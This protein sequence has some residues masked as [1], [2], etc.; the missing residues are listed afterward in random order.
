MFNLVEMKD[1]IRIPPWK[2][3]KTLTD[4]VAEELRL[5][6]ANKVIFLSI[7]YLSSNDY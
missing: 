3:R 4:A 2:F 1:I 5:K 7:Y 6:F